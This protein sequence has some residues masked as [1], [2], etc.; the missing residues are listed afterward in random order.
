MRGYL[1][2]TSY[3]VRD[4]YYNL[5]SFGISRYQRSG[6]IND[7][8]YNGVGRYVCQ[9]ARLTL[10][11]CKY[12]QWSKGV[13]DFIETDVVDYS[14]S[15]PGVAVYLKPR[16]FKSPVMV[17][18]YLNGNAHWM[19]LTK[20]SSKEIK[21]W[22]GYFTA[23]SGDP[24]MR[25]RRPIRTEW[26]SVQGPWNPFLN[27][28]TK[29][30]ISEFPNEERSKFIPEKKSATEQLIDMFNRKDEDNFVVST[31]PSEIDEKSKN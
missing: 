17:T 20:M 26:P 29:L 28:P 5:D 2:R 7:N 22:I 13:R 30:N 4:N 10:K 24:V 31:H 6:F 14:R 18:E 9:L 19:S 12:G 3:A 8:Y 23:R 1:K 11:F 25:Y 16:R 21:A 27:M 15:N